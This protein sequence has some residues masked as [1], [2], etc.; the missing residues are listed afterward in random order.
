MW[1]I[2]IAIYGDEYTYAEL[3][4]VAKLLRR[5]LL[6]V[7]DVAKVE[8]WGDRN[9]AV[10]VVP[11]RDRMS[12]LGIH[13]AQI[14]EKL[15]DKNLVADAGRARVGPE[16]IAIAPTGTFTS[17][18]EFEDLLI[19]GS[20]SGQ[21]IYLRDVADVQRGYVE[22]PSNVLQYDGHPAIG[23]GISTTQGGNVVVMGEA[24]EARMKEL[25]RADPAGGRVRCD[26]TPVRSGHDRN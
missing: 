2:F 24:I 1:G 7:K 10:Y 13:P 23:L 8:F 16:F 12:Q 15:R 3:K 9:E 4:E 6:L 26:F 19:K 11:N 17:V 5:E 21:Q 18:K 22:P 14:I 20:D 25:A